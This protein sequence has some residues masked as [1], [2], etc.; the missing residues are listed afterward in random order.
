MTDNER[1]LLLEVAATVAGLCQQED[2][3]RRFYPGGSSSVSGLAA[4]HF[5]TGLAADVRTE[6]G[7]PSRP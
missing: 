6:S 7:L 2:V 3:V 4:A 1:R 5:L